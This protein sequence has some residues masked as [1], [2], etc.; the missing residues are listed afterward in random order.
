MTCE[1]IGTLPKSVL[2]Y[3]GYKGFFVGILRRVLEQKKRLDLCLL[4]Q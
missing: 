4:Y 2:A 3:G 1:A